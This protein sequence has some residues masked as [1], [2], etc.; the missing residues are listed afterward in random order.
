MFLEQCSLFFFSFF[1]GSITA[2]SYAISSHSHVA[3]AASSTPLA[4]PCSAFVPC[5]PSGQLCL[6]ALPTAPAVS[7]GLRQ[8]RLQARSEVPQ[9]SLGAAFPSPFLAPG[10]SNCFTPA[11]PTSRSL[12]SWQPGTTAPGTWDARFIL[13]KD[14]E[15][16][17]ELENTFR[18]L[19]NQ[20]EG[21]RR[22]LE[23]S[24]FFTN[25][26]SLSSASYE[27]CSLHTSLG[28]GGSHCFTPIF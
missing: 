28:S 14:T 6:P 22:Q 26:W 15:P 8:C 18:C 7:S 24:P 17:L 1:G 4:E 5:A 27:I 12:L 21:T 23:V 16:W 9:R 13:Q 11:A 3:A 19:N 25:S 2:V 10:L 20:A